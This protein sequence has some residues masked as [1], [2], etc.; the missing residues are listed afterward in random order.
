MAEIKLSKPLAT[1]ESAPAELVQL[2][3]AVSTSVGG[4][5]QSAVNEP[6]RLLRYKGDK[7][8]AFNSEGDFVT[9][10]L[11]YK[12]SDDGSPGRLDLTLRVKEGVGV[13]PTKV[14]EY[15]RQALTRMYP[16]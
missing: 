4:Y 2:A 6:L 13:D 16:Q 5:L 3:Q 15:A 7:K 9:G 8:V 10:S 14:D 11:E 12:A 1:E